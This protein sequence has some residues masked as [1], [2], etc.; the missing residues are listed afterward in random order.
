MMKTRTGIGRIVLGL[1]L[2]LGTILLAPSEAFARTWN[3]GTVSGSRP[4]SGTFVDDDL[5]GFYGIST[6][7]IHNYSFSVSQSGTA[8]IKNFT[9]SIMH[10]DGTVNVS[11]ATTQ[12]ERMSYNVGTGSFNVRPGYTY[13]VQVYTYLNKRQNYSLTLQTPGSGGT[14]GGGTGGTTQSGGKVTATPTTG[15]VAGDYICYTFT[16]TGSATG[17][18]AVKYKS[19]TSTAICGQDFD[20]VKDVLTWGA[21]DT[22]TKKVWIRTYASKYTAGKTL[23]MRLKLAPMTQG[24]YAGCVTPSFTS[25]KVYANF[26][27]S[28]NPGRIVQTSPS[29]LKATE[30]TYCRVGFSRYGGS[31]GSIA[32]K[33]KS[34]TSTATLYSP[35]TPWGQVGYVKEILEWGS[36]ET[37]TKYVEVPIYDGGAGLQF[38]LKL[39]PMSTGLYNGNL[40]P[41]IPETKIYVPIE[42]CSR[43]YDY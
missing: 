15:N 36:G 17:K 30:G 1:G 25:T 13:T 7:Y 35:S 27:D 34:Q 41:Q 26:T 21:G 14:S 18:I 31:S 8:Y 37:G 42:E 22:S 28:R 6:R 11:V 16:R 9:A 39:A 12:D 24:A 32:V 33:V 23:A 2:A 5:G 43:C 20:Y 10:G 38:R 29:P 40:I 19:Q 4:L 3:L